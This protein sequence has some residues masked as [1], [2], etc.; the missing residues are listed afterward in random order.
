MAA[1]PR[2]RAARSEG[3]AA[4]VVSRAHMRRHASDTELVALPAEVDWPNLKLLCVPRHRVGA[5][6]VTR[7]QLMT[8]PLKHLKENCMSVC[9]CSWMHVCLCLCVC[10]PVCLWVLIWVRGCA[11][12]HVF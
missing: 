9:V 7:L 4:R 1:G 5:A 12:S 6:N 8:P 10:V 2:N 11:S 3:R